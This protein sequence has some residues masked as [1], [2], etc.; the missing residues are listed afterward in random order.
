MSKRRIEI[1]NYNNY[2]DNDKVIILDRETTFLESEESVYVEPEENI[3]NYNDHD[4]CGNDNYGGCNYDNDDIDNDN[5]NEHDN[6]SGGGGDGDGGR[7][8][9]FKT[10]GIFKKSSIWTHFDKKIDENGIKWAKC[11]YCL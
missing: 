5:D 10:I 7:I 8:N 2:N 3:D 9:S 6:G 1:D 11:K 4:D